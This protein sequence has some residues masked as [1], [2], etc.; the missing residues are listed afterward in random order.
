MAQIP[1]GFGRLCFLAEHREESRPPE[2]ARLC[3]RLYVQAR[4]EWLGLT[5]GTPEPRSDRLYRLPANLTHPRQSRQ[6]R[7]FYRTARAR[8]LCGAEA[9]RFV[10]GLNML[11]DSWSLNIAIDGN[12]AAAQG[13]RH[14]FASPMGFLI[15]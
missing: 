11:P 10:H 2:E 4:R 7:R 14:F 15:G 9:E 3:D 12:A 6:S 8:R 13:N 1:Y 5:L